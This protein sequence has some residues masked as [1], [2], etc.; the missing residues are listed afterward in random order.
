MCI[1]DRKPAGKNSREFIVYDGDRTL[2]SLVEFIST[3][4]KH[5][6]KVA[7]SKDSGSAKHDEL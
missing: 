4:G 3:N 1:R 2:E 6:A 5:H 7:I